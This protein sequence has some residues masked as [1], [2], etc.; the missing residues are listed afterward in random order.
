[1]NDRRRKSHRKPPEAGC[2]EYRSRTGWMAPTADRRPPT[3]DRRPPTADRGTGER[4]RV[5]YRYLGG[6]QHKGNFETEAAGDSRAAE[7]DAG[8][9]TARTSSPARSRR[10]S[11]ATRR[12]GRT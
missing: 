2:A 7:V 10:R 8:C 12:N 11:P 4:W 5:R 9:G 6:Q 1:M 3:A